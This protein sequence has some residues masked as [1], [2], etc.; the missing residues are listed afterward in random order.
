M[1]N[2]LVKVEDDFQEENEINIY[3]L[4][5]IFIKNIKLFIKVTITPKILIITNNL[6]FFIK[7]LIRS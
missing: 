5:S 3:N 6:I 2:N 1:S 4:I 7:I